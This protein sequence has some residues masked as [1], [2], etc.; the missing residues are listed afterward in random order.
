MALRITAITELKAPLDLPAFIPTP[1]R[2]RAQ[3]TLA[4]AAAQIDRLENSLGVRPGETRPRPIDAS[5]L[6]GGAAPT[7]ASLASSCFNP[8]Q[9]GAPPGGNEQAHPGGAA[10]DAVLTFK[11]T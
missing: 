2:R 8:T 5:L 9:R 6:A 3:E 7:S 10:A 11:S 1:Q 4:R